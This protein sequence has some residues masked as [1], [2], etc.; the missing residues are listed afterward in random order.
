MATLNFQDQTQRM[1]QPIEAAQ[2]HHNP[3]NMVGSI[4]ADSTLKWEPIEF[5]SFGRIS[6]MTSDELARKIKFAYMETFH[7]LKGVNVIYT[8][9]GFEVQLYFEY[10]PDQV[11]EGKIRNLVN[12]TA[13][14]NT[15]KNLYYKNQVIQHKVNGESFTLNDETKLLLSDCM[16]GG[17][18]ANKPKDPKWKN[19]IKEVHVPLG[20]NNPFFKP[21]NATRVMIKV[22]GLDIRKIL[23]KLY[24]DDMIVKT[25]NDGDSDMNVHAKA[26]YEI[27]YIKGTSNG[28]FIVNI[29]Q[30]DVGATQQIVA[31]ENP[32]IQNTTGIVYY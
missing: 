25:I 27:R 22:T 5:Q 14:T 13:P 32:Q 30:F 17:R 1:T 19:Y 26:M 12:L 21:K 11:P 2:P 29:E 7:D 31:Q 15:G 16:F 20:Y 23:Q 3:P 24:G 10:N 9:A 4:P 6:R 18:E 28:T 8:P